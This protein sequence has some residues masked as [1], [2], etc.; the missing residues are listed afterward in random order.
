[1]GGQQ[2]H[3]SPETQLVLGPGPYSTGPYHGPFSSPGRA[4]R[5]L[6]AGQTAMQAAPWQIRVGFG[7]WV[8]PGPCRNLGPQL[9]VNLI[10]VRPPPLRLHLAGQG[11]RSVRACPAGATHGW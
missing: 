10:Q 9:A 7:A 4:L 5:D 11:V 1:M 6:R 2:T 8:W 3:G